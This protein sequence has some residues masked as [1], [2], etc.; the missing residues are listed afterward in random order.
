MSKDCSDDANWAINER[1]F[2]INY[3]QL[4]KFDKWSISL[5]GWWIITPFANLTTFLRCR[6]WVV[7]QILALNS[8]AVLRKRKLF[9]TIR[10]VLK[11][12]KKWPFQCKTWQ[13]LTTAPTRNPGHN[14]KMTFF[15]IMSKLRKKLGVMYQIWFPG[16]MKKCAIVVIE[17]YHLKL[18]TTGRR[19]KTKELS[20]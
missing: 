15:D 10:E 11:G 14:R 2:E 18:R 16:E 13:L 6:H 20:I 5:T 7:D 9:L 8:S 4:Q 12:D 19:L 1:V 3:N 17:D